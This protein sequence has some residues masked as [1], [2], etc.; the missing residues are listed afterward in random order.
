MLLIRNKDQQQN[1]PLASFATRCEGKG[2]D[3]S[4]MQVHHSMTPEQRAWLMCSV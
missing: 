4:E 3:M 1:N 2:A